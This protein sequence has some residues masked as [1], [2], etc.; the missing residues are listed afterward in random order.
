VHV[1]SVG[2]LDLDAIVGV[3]VAEVGREERGVDEQR[4]RTNLVLLER[5]DH[6]RTLSAAGVE[7]TIVGPRVGGEGVVVGRAA[8]HVDRPVFVAEEDAMRSTWGVGRSRARRDGVEREGDRLGRSTRV[9]RGFEGGERGVLCTHCG[10]TFGGDRG[11]TLEAA[12]FVEEAFGVGTSAAGRVERHTPWSWR[13]DGGVFGDELGGAGG[14]FGEVGE[15]EARVVAQGVHAARASGVGLDRSDLA[16]EL[17]TGVREST[18]ER[19]IG[20]LERP[21]RGFGGRGR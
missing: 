8:A 17:A 21:G 19:A 3:S 10:E 7:P 4:G 18:A 12:R 1:T 13:I 9:E 2:V 14:G 16:S 20:G 6:V 15:H 11:A 5:D